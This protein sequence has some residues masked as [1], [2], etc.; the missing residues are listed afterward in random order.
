MPRSLKLY[1]VWLVAS[2]AVALLVTSYSFSSHAGFMLGMRPE[3]GKGIPMGQSEKEIQ[4]LAGLAF[5]IILSLFA[6][7]L[8]V[9]MPRGTVVSV[10][11][12]PIVAAMVLGGPVAAGWVAVLG[13]TELRELR[14]RIPWYGTLVNHAGVALPAIMGGLVADVFRS[15]HPDPLGIFVAT[16]AGASVFFALNVMI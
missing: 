4:A 1:Y 3:I 15:G 5:W 7:A 6:S 16:M 8:P 2:G 13:T 11:T 12:A 9:R 14:G 10:N